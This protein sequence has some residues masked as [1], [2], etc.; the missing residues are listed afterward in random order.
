M[1]GDLNCAHPECQWDYAQPLN[2]D[3]G[4][5]DNK[6]EHFLQNTS[7]HFYTQQEFLELETRTN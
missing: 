3:I 6:L 4:T 7:G 5:A 2:K 1:Q